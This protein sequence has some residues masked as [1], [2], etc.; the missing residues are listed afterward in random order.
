MA[1]RNTYLGLSMAGAVSDHHSV[2]R[3][4]GGRQVAWGLVPD[5]FIPAGATGKFIPAFTV[6]SEVSAADPANAGKMV[7]RSLALANTTPVRFVAETNMEEDSRNDATTG[8]GMIDGGSFFGNL[9][10]DAAG[11]PPAVL[12]GAYVDELGARFRFYEYADNRGG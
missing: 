5:T 9:M 12:P 4:P 11:G 3:V 10:P 8:Y 1:R 7:P 6:M 2:T